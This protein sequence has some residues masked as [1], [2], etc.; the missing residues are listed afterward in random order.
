M[1]GRIKPIKYNRG[2]IKSVLDALQRK[3]VKPITIA[4]VLSPP[5]KII[6]LS[7]IRE[8]FRGG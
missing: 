4:Q 5:K 8:R 7:I 1:V 6:S 3:G 2:Y